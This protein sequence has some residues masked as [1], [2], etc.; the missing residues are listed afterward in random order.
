MY[1][2]HLTLA[3]TLHKFHIVNHGHRVHKHLTKID[4]YYLG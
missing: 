4:L 1:F 2:G 3:S